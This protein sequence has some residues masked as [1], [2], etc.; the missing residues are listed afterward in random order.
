MPSTY[1]TT[2]DLDAYGLAGTAAGQIAQASA[3]VDAYL[4]RAE[5]LVW[6]PDFQGMPCDMAALEPTMTLQLTADIAPGVNVRA[7]VSG[8]VSAVQPGD[9]LVLDR[10]T[11]NVKEACVVASVPQPGET[12]NFVVLKQVRAAHT[13]GATLAMGLVIEEQRYV[14][15]GRPIVTVSRAPL[16]RLVGGVGRYSYGRRGDSSNWNMEPFNLLAAV[17]KFGGPPAWEAFDVANAGMDAGT[18][19]VW[20]PAGVMLAYYSEVK[21]RYVAGFQASCIPPAV[22]T[23]CAALVAALKD[24]PQMGNVKSYRAGDTQVESF[25]ASALDDDTKLMLAPYR[26]RMFA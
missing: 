2:D 13:T 7:A 15:D 3:L 19:Q 16:V 8:P 26:A 10:A 12:P 6:A 20:I 11:E 1:L 17:S 14:P 5:G 4:Q 21:L 24:R 18:G 23:A 25:A 9:V 22:K